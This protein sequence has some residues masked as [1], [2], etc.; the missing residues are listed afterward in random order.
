MSKHAEFLIN[1]RNKNK[2][3]LHK[4]VLS[5]HGHCSWDWLFPFFVK[6]KKD[7]YISLSR[8]MGNLIVLIEDIFMCDLIGHMSR[9]KHLGEIT[10]II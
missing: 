7:E 8:I 9:A 6:S 4:G 1:D 2:S 3:P 10:Q 5:K